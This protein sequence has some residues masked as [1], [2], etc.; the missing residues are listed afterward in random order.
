MAFKDWRQVGKEKWKNKKKN[1][2]MWIFRTGKVSYFN[3]AFFVGGMW[4]DG[5]TKRF[6]D[7]RLLNKFVKAYME[8]D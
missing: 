2:V 7:D 4:E 5:E 3:S 8:K 6:E 1:A